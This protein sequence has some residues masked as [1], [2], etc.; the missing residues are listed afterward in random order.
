[1]K[2]CQET[3]HQKDEERRKKA[4]E[5]EEKNHDESKTKLGFGP[6][7]DCAYG[8]VLTRNPRYVEFMVEEGK[9]DNT[10]TQF[11]QWVMQ[12]AME[13]LF[14]FADNLE[15]S[16]AQRGPDKSRE[17]HFEKRRTCIPSGENLDSR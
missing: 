17:R 4:N 9:R 7:A 14:G 1:M 12:R 15:I 13:T 5:K 2:R 10:K 8:E 6:Y 3:G 11:A 16:D